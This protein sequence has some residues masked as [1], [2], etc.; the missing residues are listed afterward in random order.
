MS[1]SGGWFF[2]VAAEAISV[3]NQNIMLPGIGSYIALA[4]DHKDLIA[5]TYAIIAMLVVI[6]LYDQVFFRPLISWS[7]KFRL[8]EM[9]D[10][11]AESW[12]LT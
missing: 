1:M 11:S 7:S 4:I 8:T 2:I 9:P 3:A 10:D 5:I 6:L 12:L